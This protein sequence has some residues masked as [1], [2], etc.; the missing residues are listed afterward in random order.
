[1]WIASILVYSLFLTNSLTVVIYFEFNM[2][3]IYY[4][5]FNWRIKCAKERIDLYPPCL[6]NLFWDQQY[7]N[8]VHCELKIIPEKSLLFYSNSLSNIVS[9]DFWYKIHSTVSHLTVGLSLV[10][11]ISILRILA[12]LFTF[13]LTRNPQ[14][15]IVM[16]SLLSC[17]CW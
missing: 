12:S 16:F 14:H 17:S 9:F 11:V 2:S 13:H 4:F 1:M 8:L 3:F 6:C 5:N 15:Q 7:A 10:R